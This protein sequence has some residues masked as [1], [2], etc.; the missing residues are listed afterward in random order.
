MEL[1]V[2]MTLLAIVGS[3]TA[4]A[5]RMQTSVRARVA[6]RVSAATQ[7]REALA[8]LLSDLAV[9]SPAAGDIPPGAARDSTLDLRATIAQGHVC[10]APADDGDALWI[11]LRT[12]ASSRTIVEGDS[13]WL[14]AGEGEWRAAPVLSVG[15]GAP[16]DDGCVENA[17]ATVLRIG[18]DPV[19]G[20]GIARGAPA[21]FTRLS[22]YSFYRGSDGGTYLGL[23]EWSHSANGLATVQPVAGPFVRGA[24]RFAYFD[25]AGVELPAAS[26][27]SADIAWI[28]VRLASRSSMGDADELRIS[29]GVSVALRNRR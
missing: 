14:Y 6:G 15:W 21:S 18:V 29:T 17:D 12:R 24:T 13:V 26:V 27:P 23:R 9:V 4:A 10:S 7:H 1:L 2:A 11:S 28:E 16:A 20:G 8:P 22:R 25:T 19:V 3:A 5:V